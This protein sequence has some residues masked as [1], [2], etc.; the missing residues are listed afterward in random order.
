MAPQSI[1]PTK[2]KVVVGAPFCVVRIRQ[3]VVLPGLGPNLS[4]LKQQQRF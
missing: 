1:A 2:G 4:S 3:F